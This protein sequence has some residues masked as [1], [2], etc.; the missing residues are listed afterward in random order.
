MLKTVLNPI[1]KWRYSRIVKSVNKFCD[2]QPRSS[3]A[4]FAAFY[5]LM[6][7]AQANG[8]TKEN[9]QTLL[10]TINKD[11]TLNF[12]IFG[13]FGANDNYSREQ[14]SLKLSEHYSACLF[15][16]GCTNK[17]LSGDLKLNIAKEYA[18]AL[19]TEL[20]IV[21]LDNIDSSPISDLF[22]N[23][24]QTN[25]AMLALILSSGPDKVIKFS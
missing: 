1:T 6:M 14:T 9:F 3:E 21:D 22:S 11:A 12:S 7:Y 15:L 13:I 23:L 19:G 10:Y 8:L 2:E 16:K 18:A 24:D 25:K 20:N 17:S 5:A 4:H